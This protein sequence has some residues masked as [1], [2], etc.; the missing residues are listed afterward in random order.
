MR[1]ITDLRAAGGGTIAPRATGTL[2][3]WVESWLETVRMQQRLN[4]Y[5][6]YKNAWALH[7]KPKLGHL[8]MERFEPDDVRRLYSGLSKS[9]VSQA[10]IQKVG[11]AMRRA[12]NV[13][14]RE[15]R[16]RRANPFSLV[17]LPKHD[18]KEKHALDPA[19]GAAFLEAGRGT[20]YEAAWV[21]MLTAGTRIGE[22]F[23]LEW[24]DVNFERRTITVRQ[25]LVEI[26]GRTEIAPP[27]TKGS[28]RTIDIG[29]LAVEALR[30]RKREAEREEHG[31]RFVFV[32]SIGTHPARKTLRRDHFDPIAKKA[33]V[34][35]MTPHSLR[36]SS[37]TMALIAGTSPKTLAA[38][39]GHSNP[40]ITLALYQHYV[41]ELGKQAARDIDAILKPRRGASKKR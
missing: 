14:I 27:K 41:P 10:T 39:L 3:E 11:V 31:S 33:K 4:T 23:G 24:K 7:A 22:T 18:P 25:A 5:L 20:R 21:I 17:G 40:Q 35:G 16:Y 2:G 9:R 8:K 12:F 26:G 1:K 28:R 19:Q 29:S 37:A 13:A 34:S 38:R 30:R 15:G 32:T 36:H 6:A